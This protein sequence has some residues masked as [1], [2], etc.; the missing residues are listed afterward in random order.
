VKNEETAKFR[1]GKTVQING[2]REGL[3]ITVFNIYYYIYY[4]PV[5]VYFFAPCIQN[6]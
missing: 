3:E 1:G 5:P 4:D 6:L 2:V